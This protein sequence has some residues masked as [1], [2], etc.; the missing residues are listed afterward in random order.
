MLLLTFFPLL[1]CL[2]SCFLQG[3]KS[4]V[5][6]SAPTLRMNSPSGSQHKSKAALKW[7]DTTTPGLH[8]PCPE[9]VCEFAD[10]LHPAPTCSAP[11]SAPFL[12]V[13]WALKTYL[14][15]LVFAPEMQCSVERV[16][17]NHRAIWAHLAAV[18]AQSVATHLADTHLVWMRRHQ[19]SAG[20]RAFGFW[21]TEHVDTF[22]I[23]IPH[24]CV[25]YNPVCCGK[26]LGFCV[27]FACFKRAE[28]TSRVVCK[29]VL[30]LLSRI[31]KQ[32]P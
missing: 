1:T 24:R 11:K 7:P 2:P 6:W 22:I 31:H 14:F 32:L 27:K 30:T 8:S 29:F 5:V 19:T 23:Y 13:I 10:T 18:E 21:F 12:W 25:V 28:V 3:V 26:H 16:S 4:L 9:S 20:R 17:H 15:V